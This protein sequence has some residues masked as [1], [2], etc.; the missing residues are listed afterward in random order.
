MKKFLFIGVLMLICGLSFAAPKSHRCPL[1]SSTMI[2]TGKTQTE[3]GKL[4]YEMKCSSGH[5][6]WEVDER[7]NI[8]D[9]RQS[10][11][12]NSLKC[13]YDKSSM[14]WTGETKTE[15]GKLLKKYR[16]PAGHIAWSTK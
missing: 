6:S 11:F 10:S 1:C 15:W 4:V 5:I 9:F 3:W 13:Q 14:I 8:R 12:S 7:S 2:W 16:C